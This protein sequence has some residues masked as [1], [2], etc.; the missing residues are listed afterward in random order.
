MSPARREP[1]PGGGRPGFS[2]GER[3]LCAAVLGSAALGVSFWLAGGLSALLSGR[4]WP[5][6]PLR[7]APSL[8]LGVLGHPRAPRLGWPASARADVP[9][10]VLFY[11]SLALLWL[12]LACAATGLRRLWG[13]SARRRGGG[14]RPGSGGAGA[15]GRGGGWAARREL[16]PLE[17]RRAGGGRLVLGR[18][19]GRLVACERGQS[20]LVVG[21]TQSGKT[22]GLAIPALLEWEGPVLATSVKTD[23]V[24]D[25]HARRSELGRVHVFDP[26]GV[27]PHR[28]SGWS[29]LAASRTWQGARKVAAGL[30]GVARAGGL[31]DA[32]FWYST[33]EKLLAPLLFAAASAGRSMAD[34]VRWVDTQETEEVTTALELAGVPEALRAA[35]AS[36]SREERQRSSVYTTAETVLAAYADPLV[37]ASCERHELD[38]S[39]L[40]DGGWHTAYLVAP[41]HEQERLQSVFVAIVRQVV[42]EALT[43]AS[44]RG[45][46]LEP[47]LLIVLDEAANVAPLASLDVL[48][49]T[50]ASHGVQLVTVWQD[51]AQVEARYGARAPTVVNNHRAKLYCPGIADP[52]TLEQASRL[53]GEEEHAVTSTTLDAEGRSST[54]SSVATRRL[55]PAETLRC[56][57]PGEAVLLYGHLPPARLRLRPFYSDPA[58]R[59]LAARA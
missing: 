30:C 5:P 14:R 58:L 24:R 12:L 4:R 39:A 29:P 20:L 56:L 21:P 47:P 11:A 44:R 43:L 19:G 13:A 16:S 18:A 23:L 15:G 22:S 3:A 51:L 2:R 53:I 45:R 1:A 17:V 26:V 25:S 38:P 35:E 46:P 8:L 32:S 55:A 49:A 33:A 48:A 59:R 7:E 34:V 9:G 10:A 28:G 54:T 42:E 40:L 41:S 27:T 52:A 37:E 50:A 57:V 36:F 6:V 31:D